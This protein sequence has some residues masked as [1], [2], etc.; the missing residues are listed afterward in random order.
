MKKLAYFALFVLTAFAIGCDKKDGNDNN[1]YCDQFGNC[2]NYNSQNNNCV[3]G[4]G[5]INSFPGGSNCNWFGGINTNRYNGVGMSQR[6][7]L[8]LQ[9]G[10]IPIYFPNAQMELCM[11]RSRWN[12]HSIYGR[13]VTHQG[14]YV[15]GTSG[16]NWYGGRCQSWGGGVQLGWRY[17]GAAVQFCY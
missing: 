11:E 5:G 14:A 10:D 12:Q 4:G 2:S 6:T 9:R 16:S 17:Q 3:G 15:V 8:C 13:P 7:Q 1:G